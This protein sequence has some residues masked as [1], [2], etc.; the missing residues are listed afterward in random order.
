[1]PGDVPSQAAIATAV[2]QQK[3][4]RTVTIQEM[5]PDKNE[6]VATR[7]FREHGIHKNDLEEEIRSC[8]ILYCFRYIVKASL[9]LPIVKSPGIVNSGPAKQLPPGRRLLVST[10][11]RAPLY[12][13]TVTK[14][15]AFVAYRQ[16]SML[17]PSAPP[18]R[19]PIQC[20]CSSPAPVTMMQFANGSGQAG[21]M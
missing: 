13:P 19:P 11:H 21:T 12:W 7:Q 9:Q 5:L 20:N 16:A 14:R 15:T 2:R 6:S 8:A 10:N 3:C 1:M 4:S 18:R 17:K